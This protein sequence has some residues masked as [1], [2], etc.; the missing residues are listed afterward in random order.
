MTFLLDENFPKS[1]SDLLQANGH[2]C[3]DI[4]GTELEGANDTTLIEEAQKRN[5]VI[6]ST[7]RDFYHTLRLQYPDHAG[8]IVI[9]LRKP[10]RQ[11]IL[12]RLAWLLENVAADQFP[13]RAFQ[14]RDSTCA[15]QPPLPE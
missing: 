6:L 8:L 2:E 15:A 12:E 9:A 11:A 4:R 7:D 5:A 10:N 14:L 3:V 13:K 1:A